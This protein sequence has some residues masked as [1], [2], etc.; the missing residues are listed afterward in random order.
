MQYASKECV[1]ESKSCLY[2]GPSASVKI[3]NGQMVL[4][5]F[6]VYFASHQANTNL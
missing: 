4:T 6:I 5:K 2:V 3:Y 1:Q